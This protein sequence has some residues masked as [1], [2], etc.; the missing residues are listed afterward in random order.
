VVGDE[1]EFEPPTYSDCACCGNRST[2]LVRFVSRD[3]CAFAV[4]FADFSAGHDHV[5][6]LASFGE[7]G[8]DDPDPK[9]R[10][11]IA[12]RIWIDDASFQV[13]LVDAGESGYSDGLMGRILDRHEALAHPLKQEAFDLSDHIVVCDRPIIEFLEN[14][15]RGA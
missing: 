8:G 12:M 9:T 15:P 7:W 2:H 11:A 6:V 5:S 3:A 13:G 14:L 1:I 10:T 4:Y